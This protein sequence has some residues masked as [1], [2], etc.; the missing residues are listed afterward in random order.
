MNVTSISP[1]QAHAI[2]EELRQADYNKVGQEFFDERVKRLEAAGWIL[3]VQ[4]YRHKVFKG[5][6]GHLLRRPRYEWR[7]DAYFF[8]KELKS[9]VFYWDNDGYSKFHAQDM[10]KRQPAPKLPHGQYFVTFSKPTTV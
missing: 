7:N 9:R 1:E 10:A 4:A 3:G 5:R 6:R 2:V 8:N